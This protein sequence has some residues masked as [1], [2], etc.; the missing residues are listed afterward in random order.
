M[1]LRLLI[2]IEADAATV[3]A[4]AEMHGYQA[5]VDVDPHDGYAPME[6]RLTGAV[7]LEDEV[8]A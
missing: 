3:E 2:E 5:R 7:P 8:M 6:G 1:R 4:V